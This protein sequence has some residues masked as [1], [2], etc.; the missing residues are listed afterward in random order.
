[1]FIASWA[2]N[3]LVINYKDSESFDI[4]PNKSIDQLLQQ[5]TLPNILAGLLSAA[6]ITGALETD[7]IVPLAV[8]IGGAQTLV[9]Y[10][11]PVELGKYLLNGEVNKVAQGLGRYALDSAYHMFDD[12]NIACRYFKNSVWKSLILIND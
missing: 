8:L 10:P 6:E 7:T 1:M 9:S 5:I 2:L 4:E 12:N 3:D 11:P